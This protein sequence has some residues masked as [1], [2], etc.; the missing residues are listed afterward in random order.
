MV[1]IFVGFFVF[2]RLSVTKIKE[3]NFQ[4]WHTSRLFS[5]GQTPQQGGGVQG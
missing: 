5:K 3:T 1:K 4:V 2:I